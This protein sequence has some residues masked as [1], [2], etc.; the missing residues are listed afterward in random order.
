[1]CG[2]QKNTLKAKRGAECG[3]KLKFKFSVDSSFFKFLGGAKGGKGGQQ[4]RVDQ[5]KKAPYLVPNREKQD[6]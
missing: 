3:G 4:G 5:S 1:M 2:S 6:C